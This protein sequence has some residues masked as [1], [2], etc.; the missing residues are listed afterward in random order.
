M[1][2]LIEDER[3]CTAV[4]EQCDY[5]LVTR[6][7]NGDF[8]PA[9]K[10]T[11]WATTSLQM[12]DRLSKRCSGQHTHQPLLGG[13]AADAAFYPLPLITQILRGMRDTFE[14]ENPDDTG[15]DAEI[16]H[17]MARAALLHDQPPGLLVAPAR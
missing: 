13:R 7:V 11:R 10:P 5:G 9:K 12:R 16:C 2:E 14:A 1:R 17:G 8:M 3:V 6:G 4:S 15:P